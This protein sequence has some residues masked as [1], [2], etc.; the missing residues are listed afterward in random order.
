MPII[1]YRQLH[2]P[3]PRQ[4]PRWLRPVLYGTAAVVGLCICINLI[5]ALWY[6]GKVQPGYRLGSTEVG[7]VSYDKLAE[8]LK[9]DE[10][11]PRTMT[12]EKSNASKRLSAADL[13][14]H[15]DAAA[16]IRALKAARTWLPVM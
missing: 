1:D 3:R 16:S 15:A 2:K 14:L 5:L 4:R 11:V 7:G 6:N 10:L 8:R 9:A 12:F 13:G